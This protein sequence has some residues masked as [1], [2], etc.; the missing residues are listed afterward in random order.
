VVQE[1]L[2]ALL[3]TFRGEHPDHV[4]AIRRPSHNVPIRQARIEHRESVMMLRRDGDVFH[5]SGLRQR[6]PRRGSNFIG[7]KNAAP[8]RNPFY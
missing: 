8:S 7:L 2:D 5:A 3:V 4:F 1:Q 6:H